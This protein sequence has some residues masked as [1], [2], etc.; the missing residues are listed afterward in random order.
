MITQI[1]EKKPEAPIVA[2]E[3]PKEIKKEKAPEIKPA[4]L[5]QLHQPEIAPEGADLPSA[6]TGA[7]PEKAGA[8]VVPAYSDPYYP[9]VEKIME[10]DISEMYHRLPPY[11]QHLFKVKG[12]ETAWA[13]T[14][15][16]A[17]P[18]VKVKKIIELLKGWLKIIP[19]L[20]RFFLEQAVK[21]KTDKILNVISDQG[22]IIK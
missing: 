9:K 19:G 4:T 12:E 13:I 14:K 15:I 11:E 8:P 6:Q 18:R 21:I 16:L 3:A 20:N 22:K 17:E 5:E 2:P 10:E 7:V 1:H